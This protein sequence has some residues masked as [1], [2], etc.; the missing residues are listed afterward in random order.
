[1][2]KL[3]SIQVLYEQH[4]LFLAAEWFHT[5]RNKNN[6]IE[7]LQWS[8]RIFWVC[9]KYNEGKKYFNLLKYTA[10]YKTASPAPTRLLLCS[11]FRLFVFCLFF[12]IRMFPISKNI[13]SDNWTRIK[14]NDLLGDLATN[15]GFIWKR[16]KIS[17]EQQGP[18]WKGRCHSWQI[19]ASLWWIHIVVSVPLATPWP[20]HHQPMESSNNVRSTYLQTPQKQQMRTNVTDICHSEK[21]FKAISKTVRLDPLIKWRN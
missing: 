7:L 11:L 6:F 17:P 21:R 4:W 1:M 19:I 5:Y 18:A 2:I 13:I 9:L 3:K 16:Q 12:Y 14:N 10:F 15:S 20:N 8:I